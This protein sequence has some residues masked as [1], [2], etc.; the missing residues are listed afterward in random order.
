MLKVFNIRKLMQTADVNTLDD[1][2]LLHPIF[3][4]H[5]HW[6]TLEKTD[7]AH[8]DQQLQETTLLS[9]YVLHP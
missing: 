9:S 6:I 1:D 3:Y 7:L 4:L 5:Q 8:D 2:N